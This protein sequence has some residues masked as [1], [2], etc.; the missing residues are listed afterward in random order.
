MGCRRF[1]ETCV[2][3][4]RF[5]NGFGAQAPADVRMTPERA[6]PR[7]RGVDEHAIESALAHQGVQVGGVADDGLGVET[8]VGGGGH[9]LARYDGILQP[10][11]GA[12]ALRVVV[13][14]RDEG[15][16]DQEQRRHGQA[17]YVAEYVFRVHSAFVFRL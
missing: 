15:R 2:Q 14:A 10:E 12:A 5:G 1:Q 11:V 17:P 4:G 13:A 3:L 9:Q 16:R 6:Q 7:A 8:Q